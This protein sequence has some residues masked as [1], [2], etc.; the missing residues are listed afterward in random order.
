MK[1]VFEQNMR[2]TYDILNRTASPSADDIPIAP[3]DIFPWGNSSA[4]D[5]YRPQTVAVM[6]ADGAA[7][8]VFMK[9]DEREI[10]AEEC[11]FSANVYTDSCME[12]FLLPDPVH[13][14]QYLN[15]E[16]NPAGAMY[17][18][19]GTGRYDREDIALENYPAFFQ[20]KIRENADGWTLEYRIPFDFLRRYFPAFEPRAGQVM[21]GNF[22]KC[23]DKTARPHYGCWSPIDLP[24]PDFHCSGF[25]GDLL[26]K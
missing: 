23:G 11:D 25:F 15:W 24:K 14:S 8:H 3:V 4:K 2:R 9:T 7:L 18:S 12:L 19:L 10:R 26:F 20:V 17:L 5:D 21:R 22:Y 6:T 1:A 13:S 16:F